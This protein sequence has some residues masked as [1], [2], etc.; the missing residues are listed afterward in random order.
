[1]AEARRS[2]IH[3]DPGATAF[4][5]ASTFVSNTASYRGG[6]V[7]A[8]GDTTVQNSSL[9]QN[10]KDRT[11]QTGLVTFG[12][13]GGG[14]LFT[15]ATLLVVDS[16][17]RNNEAGVNG[18]GVL[19]SGGTLTLRRATGPGKRCGGARQRARRRNCECQQRHDLYPLECH[20]LEH[21]HGSGGGI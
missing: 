1:M 14:A 4:I 13:P 16:T 21:Q 17:L 5:D 15:E 9:R 12:T 20:L 2:A 3:V 11:S 8:G 6:A 19:N 7:A 18:G 10:G